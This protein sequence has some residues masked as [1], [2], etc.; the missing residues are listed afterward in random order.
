[1]TVPRTSEVVPA[2]LWLPLQ[3]Q[4]LRGLNHALSN[5]IASLS[6]VSSLLEDRESELPFEQMFSDDLAK[7]TE[8]LELYRG[9]VVADSAAPQACMVEPLVQRALQYLSHHTGLRSHRAR[10]VVACPG[11]SPVVLHPTTLLRLLLLSLAG[12]AGAVG[13]AAASAG[14]VVEVGEEHG[15]VRFLVRIGAVLTESAATAQAF[16][17]FAPAIAQVEGRI[18]ER[19]DADGYAWEFSLPALRGA[20]AA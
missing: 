18:E 16:A 9:L 17:R 5:R 13:K 2:D 19:S 11:P 6:A 4:L 10:A 14:L 1:M 3:E 8:L 7:I 12:V 20:S 15:A